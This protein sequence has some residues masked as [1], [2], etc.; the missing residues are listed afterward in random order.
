MDLLIESLL[1]DYKK[2]PFKW[3]EFDCCQFAAI[4][5]KRVHG[6]SIKL[7]NYKTQRGAIRALKSLGGY[8]AAL[9]SIGFKKLQSPMLAQ[10]GDVVMVKNDC[11]IFPVAMALCTGLGAHTTGTIG[12]VE[13]PQNKWV[14]GWALNG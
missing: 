14:E 6:K 9:Q 4:A 8:Q 7:P 1:K 3:G 11:P 12:L 13:I 2:T 5:V 10:R